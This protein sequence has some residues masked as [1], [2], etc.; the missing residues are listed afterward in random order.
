[1]CEVTKSHVITEM[2]AY[3]MFKR[4][5][6]KEVMEPAKEVKTCQQ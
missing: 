5:E 1:M 4:E 6:N 3:A 2:W